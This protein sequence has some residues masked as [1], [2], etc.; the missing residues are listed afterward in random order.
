MDP[1][2]KW[3]YAQKDWRTSTDEDA[4][5]EPVWNESFRLP[6]TDFT[7]DEKIKFSVMDENPLKDSIVGE[8]TVGVRDLVS[9]RGKNKHVILHDSKDCG[10]LVLCPTW[11]A[12]DLKEV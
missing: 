10:F 12:H 2:V 11:E 9:K 5:K 8:V 7:A 6:C 3:K 4:G 1:Y